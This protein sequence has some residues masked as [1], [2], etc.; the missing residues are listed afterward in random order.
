MASLVNEALIAVKPMLE[1]LAITPSLNLAV[2]VAAVVPKPYQQVA[3]WRSDCGANHSLRRK[4]S[5]VCWN[6][7][8]ISCLRCYRRA[9]GV[10][11]QQRSYCN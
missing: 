5:G 4:Y 3:I 7:H 10:G 2:H 8:V 1:L 9:A 6:C 11:F